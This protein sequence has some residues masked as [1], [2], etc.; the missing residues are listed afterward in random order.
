MESHKNVAITSEVGRLVNG[1]GFGIV[2][3]RP[4]KARERVMVPVEL[5]KLIESPR[6]TRVRICCNVNSHPLFY[7]R[8]DPLSS[9]KNSQEVFV[10]QS[11]IYVYVWMLFLSSSNFLSVV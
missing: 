6:E 4:K 9:W 2:K 5:D 10:F 8:T 7:V 3:R 11:C 1:C